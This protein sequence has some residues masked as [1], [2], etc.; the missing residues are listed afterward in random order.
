MNFIKLYFI[1]CIFNCL[2]MVVPNAE[3]C[4]KQNNETYK[5]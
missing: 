3:T 4:S 5:S 2:M 1:V